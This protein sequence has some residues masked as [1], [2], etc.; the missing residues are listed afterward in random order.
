[1]CTPGE[2]GGRWVVARPSSAGGRP[3]RGFLPRPPAVPVGRSSEG[4]PG[5]VACRV[6]LSGRRP[7]S[8]VAGAGAGAAPGHGRGSRRRRPIRSPGRRDGG[9]QAERCAGCAR[10]AAAVRADQHGQGP[11]CSG[12]AGQRPL[13]PLA[14]VGSRCRRAHG[15]VGVAARHLDERPRPAAISPARLFPVR[16]RR[17][18]CLAGRR[19]CSSPWVATGAVDWGRAPDRAGRCVVHHRGN[20]DQKPGPDRGEPLGTAAALQA[21]I[22]HSAV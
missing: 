2:C 21:V 20:R 12:Q 10:P 5:S 6:H 22:G 19:C 8:S 3:L 11:G 1:M 17:C 16:A 14:A 15:P 4:R 18:S 7:G 13:G 9:A